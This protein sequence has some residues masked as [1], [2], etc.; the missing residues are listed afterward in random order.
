M[1]VVSIAWVTLDASRPGEML[2]NGKIVCHNADDN[3]TVLRFPVRP[4]PRSASCHP[5]NQVG[6][7]R[8]IGVAGR[9]AD[10]NID[11]LE[12][13]ATDA[14]GNIET[15]PGHRYG[16]LDL[17]DDVLAVGINACDKGIHGWHITGSGNIKPS[18]RMHGEGV[19]LVCPQRPVCHG[20]FCEGRS[21]TPVNRHESFGP[22]NV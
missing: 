15:G 8:H 1:N 14:P 13:G 4:P 19:F 12:R 21:M 17:V 2:F 22:D 16:S 3:I 9:A 10:T 18:V 5:V 20:Q 6:G 11:V 7:W